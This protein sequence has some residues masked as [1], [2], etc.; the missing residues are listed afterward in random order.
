MRRSLAILTCLGFAVA[1]CAHTVTIDSNPRG[2]EVSVNGRPIGKTPCTFDEMS[3]AGKVYQFK[4]EKDGYETLVLSKRQSEVN[5]GVLVG[6]LVGGFLVLV[7]FI[8][9]VWMHQLPDDLYFALDPETASNEK[10]SLVN[11]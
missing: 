8:G 5:S 11:P 9:L 10:V 3:G 7:P 2:S 6:S 1:S 4:V